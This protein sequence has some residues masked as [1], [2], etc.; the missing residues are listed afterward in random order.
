MLSPEHLIPK[1]SKHTFFI[2]LIAFLLS[3]P[4]GY[5]DDSCQLRH[6][7]CAN[8][9]FDSCNN[10]FG[11]GQC[12][13]TGDGAINE[14]CSMTVFPNGFSG[15]YKDRTVNCL[16][17][18]GCEAVN[19]PA[20]CMH[21]PSVDCQCV[22]EWGLDSSIRFEP[23]FCLLGSIDDS[24]HQQYFKCT[25]VNFNF[26]SQGYGAGL[27]INQVPLGRNC[28]INYYPDSFNKTVN[29]SHL[30]CENPTGCEG[31]ECTD[32]CHGSW[33]LN[34]KTEV[35]PGNCAANTGHLCQLK[36]L[37]C[38]HARFDWCREGYG[39]GDCQNPVSS[40]NCTLTV[41]PDH[42]NDQCMSSGGCEKLSCGACKAQWM[43]DNR[44][45][46]TPE[47]C[48]TGLNDGSCQ[49]RFFHCSNLKLDF[50][51]DGYGLGR[52]HNDHQQ[53]DCIVWL[54]PNQS[55][56]EDSDGNIQVCQQASGCEWLNCENSCNGYGYQ[57]W[58]ETTPGNC[59]ATKS[60]PCQ[61]QFF[62]C[63]DQKFD[64]CKG[65]YGTGSC[66]NADTVES[67]STTVYP[68]G[69]KA[70]PTD[71]VLCSN[72]QGCEQIQCPEGC[73]D[74][75]DCA[76]QW[77]VYGKTNVYPPDCLDYHNPSS[78]LSLALGLGITGGVILMVSA[79]TLT[80]ILTICACK[81]SGRRTYQPLN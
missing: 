66:S 71:P 30:S 38:D 47:G 7:Q 50:C 53:T 26:C 27:C 74:D 18:D 10:G 16:E 69:W 67:C 1:Y 2:A 58:Q 48:I 52:C 55:S 60:K 23:A 24:C 9:S 4:S 54:V 19:C 44:T 12:T 76:G 39:K 15:S 29:S 81:H 37:H 32:H 59:L 36:Y 33:H 25:T 8:P 57:G 63:D 20:E 79:S 13:K 43:V 11:A 49:L 5:A 56:F 28:T 34:N 22:A 6:I 64:S 17:E 40:K 41:L 45:S 73:D 61:L 14:T 51:Q 35:A 42:Q 31:I 70:S 80:A 65:G 75:C 62:A 3:Q 77:Q 68:N 46:I 21:D 72:K 78:S